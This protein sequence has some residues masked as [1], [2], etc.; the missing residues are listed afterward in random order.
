MNKFAWRGAGDKAAG[1]ETASDDKQQRAWL[2]G[3]FLNEFVLLQF[4][5]VG[6]I[7]RILTR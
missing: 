3:S 5:Q 7:A 4:Y 2:G 6:G 1:D